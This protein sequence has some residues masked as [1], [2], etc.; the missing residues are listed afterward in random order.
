MVKAFGARVIGS[1]VRRKN[2]NE[3][4]NLKSRIIPNIIYFILSF[5]I[6]NK[7]IYYK[8][9]PFGVA[10]AAGVPYNSAFLTFFGSAVSYLVPREIN[11]SVKYIAAMVIII[12]VRWALKDLKIENNK[13]YSPI[14]CSLALFLISVPVYVNGNFSS[15]ILLNNFFESLLAGVYSF[16]FKES[17]NIF[18]NY[19]FCENK[20]NYLIKDAKDLVIISMSV[21]ALTL[22]LSFVDLGILSLGRIISIYLILVLCKAGGALFASVAS[23]ILEFVF[24]FRFKNSFYNSNN[25]NLL[26][27][28]ICA[29]TVGLFSKLEKIKIALLYIF[30]NLLLKLNLLSELGPSVILSSFYESIL[31]SV[32]FLITPKYLFKK[33]IKLGINDSFLSSNAINIKKQIS[34]KLKF[35]AES[36]KNI[37]SSLDVVSL[38]KKNYKNDLLKENVESIKEKFCSSCN[39][40]SFCWNFSDGK[41]KESLENALNNY[42]TKKSPEKS[43][44]EKRCSNFEKILNY[45][46]LLHLQNN[47]KD[48]SNLRINEIKNC[49][50]EQLKNIGELLEGASLEVNKNYSV[51]SDVAFNLTKKLKKRGINPTYFLC[52]EGIE[53]KW[54]VELSIKVSE[55]ERFKKINFSELLEDEYNKKFDAPILTKSSEENLNYVILEKTK[56]KVNFFTSQHICKNGNFCGDSYKY[57]YTEDGYFVAVLSDGMGT[58]VRAAVEG[59]MVCEILSILLKS[60]VNFE[61][62]LKIVNTT[63]LANPNEEALVAVDIVYINLNTGTSDFFKVGGA[64][65]IVKSKGQVQVLEESSLPIGILKDVRYSVEKIRLFSEDKVLIMSDGACYPKLDWITEKVKN[66]KNEPCE[67]IANFVVEKSLNYRKNDQDDDITVIALEITNND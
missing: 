60:G 37:G 58:G 34:L 7:S 19:F 43:Y 61:V 38:R 5:F 35:L 57:F 28:S 26:F 52:T 11:Y 15:E 41:A 32:L 40:N 23:I 12:T 4:V 8:F 59:A 51:K 31:A 62:A 66:W 33:I 16:F 3:N 46:D 56:Y 54:K 6:S 64:S 48:T 20:N 55:E 1:R 44:L 42:Q 30:L 2:E 9:F 50:V 63:L 45:I 13:F 24:S 39:L 14:I 10:F 29:L 18:G 36:L 21:F 49:M 27:S 22:S 65:S 17:I 53:G 47:I 25:Y 67:D